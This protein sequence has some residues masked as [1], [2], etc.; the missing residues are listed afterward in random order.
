MSTF[1]R[2][3]ALAVGLS[4]AASTATAQA[5]SDSSRSTQDCVFSVAQALRG[6]RIFQQV[7]TECHQ[8]AEFSE[9]GY[10]NAWVGQSVGDLFD[11]IRDDMPYDNP[12][13][14]RLRQY[15][16]IVS[17]LL[18][19]NGVPAGDEEMKGDERTLRQIRIDGPFAS[20]ERGAG[21]CTKETIEEGLIEWRE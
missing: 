2:A 10:L 8:P 18:S 11:L 6:Q 21:E 13:R 20:G 7:C 19:I 14:L 16:D 15:V 1:S 9:S 17:Y 5:D 4:T 3:L 12:G